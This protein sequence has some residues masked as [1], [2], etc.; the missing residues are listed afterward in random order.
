MPGDA[1][2]PDGL[3]SPYRLA[4]THASEA[5][6]LIQDGHVRAANPACER[7]L[8]FSAA[9]LAD[10]QFIDIVHP[11]DRAAIL[12]R[13]QRRLAG[14]TAE[15]RFV[16]RVHDRDGRLRWL[17]VYSLP[18]EW[19]GQPAVLTLLTEVS[20]RETH[21]LAE[22][23]ELFIARIAEVTPYFL[24]IYDYE[25]GRDVYINRSVSAALGYHGADAQALEPYPFLKLCHPDDV[26]TAL[27]R[28]ARWQG[29]E[30]GISQAVEFRLRHRNG[31]WRWFRSHNIPFRRDAAGR[32]VQILGMSLDVTD[33]KRAAESLSRTERLESLGLLAGGIA[34]D[35]GNL[36]TPIL[37]NIELALESPQLDDKAR[38]R[39][40]RARTASL[41][42][43]DLVQLLLSYAGRAGLEPR[44][45]DFGSLV[46]GVARLLEPTLPRGVRLELAISPGLPP[47][48]GDA[49]QL[50][51]V[52]LNLL[53]N[54]VEAL[55]GREGRLRVDLQRQEL[56][57]DGVAHLD[58]ADGVAAGPALVLAV[59]DTGCGMD[60]E[61]RRH[62][63][64]P[65]FTT[66]PRG[67]GLGLASVLGILRRHHAG[68][69]VAS[70]PGEGTTFRVF[71][72]LAGATPSTLA[73]VER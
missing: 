51:Q 16:F 12:D 48:E 9:E 4:F 59:A 3:E 36:L 46:A 63:F 69:K 47:I 64:E 49:S 25:L 62:L 45:L 17:E 7:L 5:M 18:T 34:H 14:D 66:K 31:E 35:F 22:Q 41:H 27:D 33:E 68:L 19:S 21:R 60:D 20:D 61:T 72:P 70:R 37:G 6:A 40:E 42:A 13:Y 73:A 43:A 28:D 56:E 32:V 38:G 52:V 58:V 11:E 53:T 65:F 2:A 67:R 54:A 39:L 57:A 10:R 24:F 44:T 8:G 30:E 50:R 29:V 23:R 71:L 1:A 26:R 15:R 55:Q